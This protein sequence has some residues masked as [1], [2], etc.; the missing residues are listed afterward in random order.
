MRKL[1]QITFLSL[2]FIVTVAFNFQ[3]NP[4][5]NWYQQF[6]NLNGA[7]IRDISFMDSL[8]GYM[9][10][11]IGGSNSYIF[12]TT[13]GGDNWVTKYLHTQPFVR[14]QFVNNNTGFT[15]AF[16]KIFKTTNAG[17]NWSVINLPDIFGDD[18]FVL[19]A[20]TIWL[21]MSESLT[22]GVYR[23]T[24]GGMNWQRQYSQGASNPDKI[25]MY[26]S[27]IGFMTRSVAAGPLYKTTNSGVNWLNVSGTGFNDIVF[28]D[29]LT[30]WKTFDS[31]YKSTN[32]GLNWINQPVP[33]GLNIG[34]NSELKKFSVI[35]KDTLLGIGG[36]V[37]YGTST[38]RAFIYKTTNGGNNWG[39]QIPDTSF[40]IPIFD[41]INIVD[42]KKGWAY[43]TYFSQQI[44]G[45]TTTGIHTTT[46]G[47]TT[48]LT[49]I[50]TS[51]SSVAHKSFY[52][53]Q[54]Y[55]NPFN[56]S[57]KINYEL[58]VANYV[59]I[60]VYDLQG[61]AIETLVNKKQS[62]GNYS[63]DFNGANLSSGIYFY[64]LQAEDFKETKKMMLIK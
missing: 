60:K 61:R 42:K 7:S 39:Y 45:L 31:V 2:I 21:A 40:G 63:V 20:D 43:G 55:P 23:T 5:S 30:G 36:W 4:P 33:K 52:L 38:T 51:E 10:T 41:R 6:V 44:G 53:S 59:T 50:R 15:N 57:T 34:V 46:G 22:G 11:S 58:K 26:N 49:N 16:N 18:M 54:N 27:R 56:P 64:S 9:V 24:N 12:K 35:S 14:V 1:K 32:G 17:E 8:T 25:N 47:D 13:N 19:N 48:F 29:S 3:H 62:A 28:I 37:N